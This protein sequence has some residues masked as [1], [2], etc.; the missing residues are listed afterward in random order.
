MHSGINQ[1]QSIAKMNIKHKIQNI[2]ND[3]NENWK[4]ITKKELKA[5]ECIEYITESDSIEHWKL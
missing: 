4:C 1:R 3:G 5:I 2:S